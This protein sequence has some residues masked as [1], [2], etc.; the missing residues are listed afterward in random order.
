MTSTIIFNKNNLI[1]NGLNNSFRFDF[2]GSSV[3]FKNQEIALS[4]LQIYNSQFNKSDLRKR[5]GFF[6][7]YLKTTS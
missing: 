4:S 6:F 3:N 2:S 5:V 1:N 7:K